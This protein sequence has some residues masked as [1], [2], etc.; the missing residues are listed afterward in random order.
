M[1]CCTCLCS[2]ELQSY[3]HLQLDYFSWGLL[4]SLLGSKASIAMY[5]R[6]SDQQSGSSMSKYGVK[7]FEWM[8]LIIFHPGYGIHQQ[9]TVGPKKM[10]SEKDLRLLGSHLA[11]SSA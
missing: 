4:R 6:E 5:A 8:V 2:D 1:T 9:T 7:K 11:I 10:T 3:D